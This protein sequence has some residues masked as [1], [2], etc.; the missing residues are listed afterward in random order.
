MYSLSSF[1]SSALCG[2]QTAFSPGTTT[3]V[4]LILIFD[5]YINYSDLPFFSFLKIDL[6]DCPFSQL[7]LRKRITPELPQLQAL[8]RAVRPTPPHSHNHH[9]AFS[10]GTT[11]PNI[12]THPT[13][14]TA[15]DTHLDTNAA[16]GQTLFKTIAIEQT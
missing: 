11:S 5:L 9:C 1:S 8:T 6:N 3:N 12:P 14:W 7:P 10:S 2:S 15:S 13:T 16:D 4:A